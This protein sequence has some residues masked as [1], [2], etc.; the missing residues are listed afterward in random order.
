MRQGPTLPKA[1][2]FAVYF[3]NYLGSRLA[4]VY[5]DALRLREKSTKY[6]PGQHE[7]FIEYTDPVHYGLS[8]R[9]HPQ[10]KKV[11]DHLDPRTFEPF[12]LSL[13]A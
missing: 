3:C 6:S 12:A 4:K 5:R 10:T 2:R 8:I 7:I 9:S 1:I 13:K 11:L